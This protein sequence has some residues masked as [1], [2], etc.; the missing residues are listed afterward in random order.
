MISLHKL[1]PDD[2]WRNIRPLVPV[3]QPTDWEV[4]WRERE[5]TSSASNHPRS[6]RKLD[7][8][9][10]VIHRPLLPAI[11]AAVTVQLIHT[12]DDTEVDV[13]WLI[14]GLETIS[15]LRDRQIIGL[16]SWLRPSETCVGSGMCFWRLIR[17]L[18]RCS[19]VPARSQVETLRASVQCLSQHKSSDR[20]FLYL[21]PGQ[22]RNLSQINLVGILTINLFLA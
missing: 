11:L 16:I 9:Q 14:S 17:P 10:Q 18:C 15:G 20:F 22:P 7:L 4:K 21:N 12:R 13:T 8:G 2:L 6:N 3:S 5:C 19:W 1:S